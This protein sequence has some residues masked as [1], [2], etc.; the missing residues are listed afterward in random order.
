MHNMLFFGLHYSAKPAKRRKRISLSVHPSILRRIFAYILF[1]VS[2]CYRNKDRRATPAQN[3]TQ[4]K[5]PAN[6]WQREQGDPGRQ[7]GSG[8]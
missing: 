4:G 3:N 1:P 2:L 7:S 8:P 5:G 6:G